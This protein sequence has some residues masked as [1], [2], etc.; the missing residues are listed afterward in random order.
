MI[1]AVIPAPVQTEAAEKVVYVKSGG[2]DSNTGA[3]ASSAV[4]NLSKAFELL[5][6]ASGTIVV[7]GNVSVSSSLTTPANTGTVTITSVYGGKDYRSS[8][9]ITITKNIT[10]GCA[11]KLENVRIITSV[12]SGATNMYPYNSISMKGYAL[13][14]GKG[15]EC[16]LANGCETYLSIVGGAGNQQLTVESGHW[17][18]V[19]GNDGTGSASKYL[20]TTISV[21]GGTFHEK[22]ILTGEK[23]A[24]Y[25]NVNATID[26]GTFLGGIYLVAFEKD[27]TFGTNPK[28]Y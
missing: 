21:T 11:L 2:N 17:Q 16:S 27:G 7:C 25:V 3:S 26:G 8:A 4:K 9:A 18:R 28:Y 22:L 24:R 10:M 15:V 19:R 20:N 13:H 5:G 6:G 23:S 14:I 1:F 12:V